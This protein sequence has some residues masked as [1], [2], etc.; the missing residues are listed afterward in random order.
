MTTARTPDAAATSG[1]TAA[2]VLDWTVV[3]EGWGRKAADFATL[4]EPSNCREY[5]AVHH[6]LGVDGGDRLVDVAC[7]SGLAIELAAARGA[8]C[9]GIDASPRLIAVARDR[10]P[11][12]DV[13]VGDMH[14][15]PWPDASFDVAT[16][17]RGVWN[18]TPMAV[19]EIFRVLVPGGRLGLSAWG[20]IKQSPGAWALAPFRLAAVAKVENQAAMQLGRPGAGEDLLAGAGFVDVERFSVPFAWEFA[21]PETFARALA[22]TGP[23]YE[24][25]QTIGEAA[26]IAAAT[27]QARRFVRDGLPL[28][29]RI[30]MVG[31]LA[32]KPEPEDATTID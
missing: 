32:R 25:I 30:D 12:A 21:D 17:F 18:T 23:A 26:F 27:E 3:D 14:A 9:A 1:S 2:A 8:R 7:G 20:H 6:R 19:R 15:L 13:R 24:A 11:H 22:S 31:F 16:S 4:S 10:N 5:V 28:R 29:A